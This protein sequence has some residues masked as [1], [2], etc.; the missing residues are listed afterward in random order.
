MSRQSPPPPDI[1]TPRGSSSKGGSSPNDRDPS[2]LSGPPCR[3]DEPLTFTVRGRRPFPVALLANEQAWP[4]SGLDGRLIEAS[5]TYPDEYEVTLRTVRD[6]PT[7]ARWA[8]NGWTVVDVKGWT[9]DDT[10][11]LLTDYADGGTDTRRRW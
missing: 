3:D 7:F 1:P 9:P 11:R 6:R 10:L 8:E 5:L 2:A 4:G